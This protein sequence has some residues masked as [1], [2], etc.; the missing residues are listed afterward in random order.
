MA[1]ITFLNNM[2][3]RIASNE[4]E[5]NELNINE[6]DYVIKEINDV[7]FLKIKKDNPLVSLENNNVS[8]V[9][10]PSEFEQ[11]Q[12]KSKTMLQE[13]HENL[14]RS[15]EAFLT[16]SNSSKS[17][18]ASI[19]DYNNYLKNFDYDSL[20]YPLNKTWEQYCNDNSINYINPL[21]IP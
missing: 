7:D 17:L 16:P 9:D 15:F 2:V 20:T 13:H 10:G 11:D 6:N 1:Y 3:Y 18:Y 4:V 12:E 8:I 5:K 14:I 21:Q 19:N